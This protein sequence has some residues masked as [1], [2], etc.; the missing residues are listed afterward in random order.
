M[1]LVIIFA[2]YIHE[3]ETMNL[4][5]RACIRGYIRVGG[6]AAGGQA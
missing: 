4:V 3:Q 2:L 1:L 6:D 5:T